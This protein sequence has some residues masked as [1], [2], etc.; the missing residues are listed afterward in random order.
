MGVLGDSGR[1]SEEIRTLGGAGVD[2]SDLDGLRYF[3]RR[4]ESPS[5]S[6]SRAT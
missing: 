1:F 2:S 3:R 6:S 4:F 5:A